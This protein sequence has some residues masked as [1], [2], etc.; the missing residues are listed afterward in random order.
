M[1]DIKL[2]AVETSRPIWEP[3][4]FTSKNQLH[5]YCAQQVCDCTRYDWQTACYLL[6]GLVLLLLFLNVWEKRAFWC[7]RLREFKNEYGNIQ[8]KSSPEV[9]KP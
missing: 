1:T 3:M 5:S 9:K 4:L 7:R 8:N 2:V 6:T